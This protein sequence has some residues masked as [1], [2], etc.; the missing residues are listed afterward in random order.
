M[1]TRTILV[2]PE[3]FTPQRAVFKIPAGTRFKAKKL[4]VINTGL[5][6]VYGDNVYFGHNGVYQLLS[7]VSL[8]S[9]NGS[10][11]DT[12]TNMDY[13][14]IKLLNMSNSQEFAIARQLA[15]N[16]GSSINCPS[17]SQVSLF[18]EIGKNDA[19]L[20]GNSLYWDISFMLSFLQASN[21]LDDGYTV[22]MEFAD[23]ATAGFQYQLTRPPVLAYDECLVEEPDHQPI[24][25]YMQI[26]PDRIIM[27]FENS[28]FV[29]RLNAFYNNY[30]HNLYYYNITSSQKNPNKFPIALP[31]EKADFSVNGN[32]IM[33]LRGVNSL[34]KKLVLLNDLH[35]PS[36]LCNYQAYFPVSYQGLYNPNKGLNYNGNFAYGSFRLDRMILTDL[37][38]DYSFQQ[39]S[40]PGVNEF[41]T[42]MLLA[43]VA[44]TYNR[45]TDTVGYV[46]A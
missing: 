26:I 20:S 40:A 27:P 12:L 15:Q 5:S 1:E 42:F 36:A 24:T 11:I 31:L 18:E 19:S 4:R 16:M 33:P 9:N 46:Y 34:S 41:Y 45:L 37:T 3:S 38:L 21:V 8:Y 28:Q 43:Q 25:A 23:F 29:R 13:M 30:V 7:R 10:L 22:L 17:L 2:D 35:A 14:G 44:R 6:N 32:K 39:S